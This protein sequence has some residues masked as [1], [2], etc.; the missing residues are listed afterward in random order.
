MA[1]GKR[2]KY[3]TQISVVVVLAIFALQIFGVL[4]AMVFNASGQS[5]SGPNLT[6]ITLTSYNGNDQSGV[7]DLAAGKIAAY[8]FALTPAELTELNSSFS[9]ISTPSD[10]FDLL[11]NPVNT[12]FGFNPFQFAAVRQAVNYVVDR[13]YFV[14]T[15]LG[16]YG[17]PALSALAGEPD[18]LVI[19]NT[20]AVYSNYSQ[21]NLALANQTIYNTLTANGATYAASSSGG[22]KSWSYDGTPI[23]IYII[24]RTDDPTRDTYAGFLAAQFQDL[25]FTVS[26]VPAT[27]DKAI[28]LVYS[29]DPRNS[30]W[31]IYPEGWGAAYLY[32]DESLPASLDS[33]LGGLTP[34]TDS[35]GLSLGT[36]NDSAYEQPDLIQ[37]GNM[38]DQ[39]SLALLEG[40]FTSF[41]QR[42]ALLN[43]VTNLGFQLGVRIYLATSLSAYAANPNLIS[44]ITPQF[45]ED[46]ILNTLSYITMKSP[47]GS[48]NIGV[49]YIEQ[50]SLNP[51]GGWND[52]YSVGTSAAAVLPLIYYQPSTAYDYAIGFN[53]NIDSISPT[54]NTA[55]P[56]SA[57]EYNYTDGQFVHV[58]NGTM[59]NVAVNVN[60]APLMS[61]EKWSDGQPITL[62]DLIYQYVIFENASLS[63]NSSI[64]DGYANSDYASGLAPIMGF[65]IINS[66]SM[67]VYSTYYYPDYNFAALSDATL[68]PV[69]GNRLPGGSMMPWELYQAMANVVA[70]GKAAWSSSAAT[71]KSIDWLNLVSPTDLGYI[72][73]QLSTLA[74]ESYVPPQ[75]TQIQ[76]MTGVNMTTPSEA[77]AGYSAISA[78][79]TKYGNAVISDGPY[80]ISQWQTTTTPNYAVLTQNPYFSSS[81]IPAALFA[82]A[83]T[84]TTTG[85]I[86]SLVPAGS[87]FNITALS[88][89]IGTNQTTPQAGV[90]VVVQ[91][92]GNSS[93]LSQTSTVTGSDGQATITVPSSI[94]SGTYTLIVYG[95]SS[96]STLI[97]PFEASITVIAATSSSSAT[98][99]TTST[100]VTISATTTITSSS[101]ST[102]STYTSSSS[103]APPTSTST[104]TTSSSSS[105]TSS[106]T[107]SSSTTT[108]EV[109]AVVVVIIIIVGAV[110][111]LRRR[112][113]GSPPPATGT[114]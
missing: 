88:T 63:S 47:T 53:Y 16:G 92:V 71:A 33:T 34:F 36:Y 12:S 79:I 55:V 114:T 6:S 98:T 29:S 19:A 100:S 7:A 50:G 103:T 76:N 11:L 25:G 87:T 101:S 2:T 46:P 42:S 106:S 8:D 107:S 77:A 23:T 69:L 66:T 32:Y 59:A 54:A 40:Q 27:L 113:G 35:L 104:T 90:N 111:A 4:P 105:S 64:Y 74:S 20:T 89:L 13:N 80:V 70:S 17:I 26:L 72:S 96:A 109:A 68:A 52:E 81:V 61:A 31:D 18:S 86:P 1:L 108:L 15:L 48:A 43:N 3:F 44:N 41:A 94:P 73:S 58:P 10:L 67:T 91:I 30:T 45:V 38:A 24:Q 75:L 84:I 95:S 110:V 57:L 51:V 22:N 83:T 60:Y 14:D 21:Y 56:T 78:F 37:N 28:T 62:A 49:R 65:Q 102:T 93:V 9:R 39:A 112:G 97:D 82:P 99:S 5:N 85:T